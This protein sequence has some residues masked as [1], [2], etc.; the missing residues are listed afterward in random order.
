M[1]L[2]RWAFCYC[3]VF[4][5]LGVTGADGLRV[6]TAQRAAEN[7]RWKAY[8]VT[9]PKGGIVLPQPYRAPYSNRSFIVPYAWYR[10]FDDVLTR[11]HDF[12]VSA[13]KVRA[14]LPTLRLLAE[15]TYAG[16]PTAEQRGWKWDAWFHSWDARL[17]KAGNKTLTL[18]QAFAPWGDLERFQFDAH[19]GIAGPD[20]AGMPK[21]S[22]GSASATLARAP[23]GA[24][25][26]L[27]TTSGAHPLDAKDAGQ[28]PHAVQSWDGSRFS[29]AWYVSYPAILGSAQSMSCGGRTVALAAVAPEPALPKTPSYELLGSGVAYI[30]MPSFSEAGDDALR[31]VLSK[32]GTLGKEQVVLLDL[33]GNDGGSAPLDLL[34]TWF[35][36]G[37]VEEAAMPPDRISTTSCFKTALDFNLSQQLLASVKTPVSAALSQRIQLLVDQVAKTAPDACAVKPDIEH[38]QGDTPP[39]RFTFNRTST[40]EPRI[41]AI[42]DSKC[43]SDCE[44]MAIVLSHLP[45]T[46]IVG[47]STYGI[48]GFTQPGYFVLPNSRV[49]FRLATS[50]TD[51]YGDGR[52][53]DGYGFSVDVLLPTAASQKRSSLLALAH[54]LSGT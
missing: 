23:A 19:S 27:Q 16:Y 31:A 5:L 47:E 17:A 32:V 22:S 15:K 41:I 54:A 44:G 34:T 52:S 40:D 33:R 28:Q 43:A 53:V 29:P 36:G 48:I 8:G 21:F 18:A 4:A 13:A 14:D 7:A 1:K 49:P 24:C 9:L 10:H 37:A 2:L 42:V 50:R 46:V 45:N 51:P 26:V 20:V 6:P 35:A 38:A 3:A 39:H 25:T 30:R 11:T 12:P